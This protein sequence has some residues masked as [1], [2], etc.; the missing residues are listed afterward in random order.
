MSQTAS[1]QEREVE[2]RSEP[3][4]AGDAEDETPESEDSPRRSGESGAGRAEDW[5]DLRMTLAGGSVV[6]AA[7]FL[8]VWSVGEAGA[9]E[10]RILLESTLPAIRFLAS[11]IL[12]V[13]ATVLALM[14][15][16]L[17]FSESADR[18]FRSIHYRRIRRISLLNVVAIVSAVCLLLFIGIP[19]EESETL[20]ALYDIVYYIVLA[21]S[22]IIGGLAVAIVLLLHR[23]IKGLTTAVSPSDT[24]SAFT[25]S[26]EA[27][28]E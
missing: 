12:T 15:T 26:S 5:R 24:T 11:S 20:R 2:E 16:L 23:T 27:A 18:R 22:S 14:L 17:G 7:L 4:G 6:A 8:I 10:A 25:R 9:A 1:E 3:G 19:V 21:W 13:G 28:S